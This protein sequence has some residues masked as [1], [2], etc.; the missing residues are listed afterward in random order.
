M[1]ESTYTAQWMQDEHVSV[2]AAW[3]GCAEACEPQWLLSDSPA[4]LCKALHHKQHNASADC[5]VS[6][7]R[8]IEVPYSA[9]QLFALEA[10]SD[11]SS[12]PVEEPGPCQQATGPCSP[13]QSH[14][15]PLGACDC[16]DAMTGSRET[17]TS[18]EE[19]LHSQGATMYTRS[20][21]SNSTSSSGSDSENSGNKK[22]HHLAEEDSKLFQSLDQLFGQ[23]QSKGTVMA[24]LHR[25]RLASK[26]SA[27]PVA[28]NPAQANVRKRKLLQAYALK[29][30]LFSF[31]ILGFSSGW[32]F[33]RGQTLIYSKVMWSNSQPP[34]EI[35]ATPMF[36]C[37][38]GRSR[39]SK[40]S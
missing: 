18:P 20:T 22:C 4:P 1:L 21:C 23:A 24:A 3:E 6:S 35:Y 12:L 8:S 10:D 38:G 39:H 36:L 2:A 15:I 16:E 29:V 32:N 19:P 17:F 30:V 37:T 5:I 7:A 14:V 25:H 13:I 27:S 31:E 11:T 40:L 9:G 26:G 28:A 33:L 34:A